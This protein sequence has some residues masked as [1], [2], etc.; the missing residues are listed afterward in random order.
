[1]RRRRR[2]ISLKLL[3]SVSYDVEH[4]HHGGVIDESVKQRKAATTRRSQASSSR[5]APSS[6]RHVSA[7]A[8]LLQRIER[9][10]VPR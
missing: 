10:C 9:S 6:W 2:N 4:A 1:M 5:R 3:Q 8:A 7:G